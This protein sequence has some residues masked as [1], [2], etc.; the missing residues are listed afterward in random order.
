MGAKIFRNAELVFRFN[1][2]MGFTDK[3]LIEILEAMRTPGG[4]KLSPDQWQALLQTQSSAERSAHN[5]A[6]QRTD[7]T[8]YHGKIEDSK[9]LAVEA[10]KRYY[11]L[12]GA[13]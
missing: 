2:A 13:I 6:A 1:T 5:C 12:P 10:A 3:T 9:A 8:W 4:R 11:L 7:L